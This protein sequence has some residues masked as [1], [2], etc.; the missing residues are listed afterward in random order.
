MKRK[1]FL[2]VVY[3]IG[4]LLLPI[5][6]NAQLSKLKGLGYKVKEKVTQNGKE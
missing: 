2:L 5:P 3:L 4:A 6:T 1:S